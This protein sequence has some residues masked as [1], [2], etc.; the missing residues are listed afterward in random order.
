MGW[1][2]IFVLQIALGLTLALIGARKVHVPPTGE[3]RPFD[4][5]GFVV[6]LVGLTALLVA[7][8][9]A[10]TWG[11]DSPAT[12]ALFLAGAGVLVYFAISEWGR[13]NPLLDT[14]LLG[15]RAFRGITTAMF[16]AQFILTG[17][18]IYIATYFQHILGYGALLASVAMLPAFLLSP[19]YA[20]VIG[21]ITDRLGARRP[22]I[23]GFRLAG[24]ALVWIA[25][26]VDTESYW[27]LV[28]GL[29]ALGIAVAPMFT[30]LVTALSNA[31]EA[32]ERGDANALVLTIRWIGAAAGT[33]VLGVVIHS[34][35]K[36]GVPTDSGYADAFLVDAARRRRRPARLRLPAPRPAHG[37]EAAEHRHHH[38]PHF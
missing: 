7:L 11:V 22:A 4:V 3:P 36:G 1:R 18:L 20:F 24:V 15:R 38:R 27:V 29:V 12:I 26:F 5:S 8:M 31:V 25:I 14:K 2:A 37:A 23:V 21:G 10:L 6:L 34:T 13:P 30:A 19:Y 17:F 32:D 35:E 16:A 28:P 9:Q 33:M